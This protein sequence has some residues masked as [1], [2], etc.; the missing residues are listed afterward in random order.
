MHWTAL[1]EKKYFP[2]YARVIDDV[3]CVGC[4]Y[5]LR[6]SRAAG[7]CPECGRPIIDSLWALAKAALVDASAPKEARK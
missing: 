7:P 4:G 1:L 2:V 3:S 5:N 6:H